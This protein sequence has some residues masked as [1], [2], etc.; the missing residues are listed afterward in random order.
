MQAFVLNSQPSRVLQTA[1][2]LFHLMSW[3][4]CCVYF[5]GVISVLGIILLSIHFIYSL[6]SARLSHANAVSR[7]EID[8]RGRATIFLPQQNLAVEAVLQ[9][10]SLIHQYA[11]FLHWQTEQHHIW[12]CLLPD[13]TDKQ[14][15]RRLRVWA[16]F[17]TYQT[18]QNH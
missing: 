17:G 4:V 1:S 10:D 6:K 11:C 2:I 5:D 12:Q 3:L 14:A 15:F 13:M 16:K 18:K 9:Q 7:I 8:E